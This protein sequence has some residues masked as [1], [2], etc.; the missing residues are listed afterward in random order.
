MLI[1]HRNGMLV[2]GKRLP[3]A[4][5][6]QYIESDGTQYIDT[7]VPVVS[8]LSLTMRLFSFYASDNPNP[9]GAIDYDIGSGS[10]SVRPRFFGIVQGTRF[11][12]YYGDIEYA[13]EVDTGTSLAGRWV[14]IS[15]GR[16]WLECDGVR[17][18]NG[19]REN[20][21][22]TATMFLFAR[23]KLQ[24]GVTEVKGVNAYRIG[25]VTISRGGVPVRD[26]IPVIDLNGEAKMFDLATQTYPIHYGTFIAGP[27]AA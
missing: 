10:S 16:G 9:F 21:D 24:G 13:L 5:R 23:R 27:D 22:G 17:S 11:R 3:Y 4:R 18:T 1:A 2:G 15:C 26:F 8:D 20:T 25:A 7:G 14:D 19:Q 12:M 6:L